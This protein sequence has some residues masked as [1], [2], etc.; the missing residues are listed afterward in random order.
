LSIILN[1]VLPHTD[2]CP[3]SPPQL[4]EIPLVPKAVRFNL[5]L[6]E[7]RESAFPLWVPIAMPEITIDKDNQT[8]TW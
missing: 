4:G 1:F 7:S 3:A 6:P 5:L 2:H 8:M